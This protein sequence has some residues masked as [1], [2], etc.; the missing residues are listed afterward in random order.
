MTTTISPT[1]RY[2]G[3]SRPLMLVD[4]WH[5]VFEREGRG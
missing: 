5:G 2:E 4:Y 3:L 1:P